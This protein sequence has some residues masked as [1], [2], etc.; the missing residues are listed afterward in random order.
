M[1]VS[2]MVATELGTANRNHSVK[3]GFL[4][5]RVHTNTSDVFIRIELNSAF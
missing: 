4:F 3:R 1:D 2:S 5:A